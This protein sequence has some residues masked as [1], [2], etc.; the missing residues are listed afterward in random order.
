MKIFQSGNAN[1]EVRLRRKHHEHEL[2]R[3]DLE[4]HFY[5]IHL[6]E[7]R[8]ETNNQP[9]IRPLMWSVGAE[10]RVSIYCEVHGCELAVRVRA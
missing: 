2:L 3:E 6:R 8:A 10:S 1:S 9:S 4:P 7:F 5:I